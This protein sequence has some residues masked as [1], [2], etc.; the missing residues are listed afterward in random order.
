[1][2]V[3][4][5]T[6]ELAGAGRAT[7][8]AFVEPQLATLVSTPPAKGYVHEMKFD[9][10]RMLAR[11]QRGKVRLLTR[12]GNDWTAR[13]P[14]LRQAFEALPLASAL[15]DGEVV[16][17]AESGASDFQRLQNSLSAGRDGA[18]LYYAFD[19]LHLL[20]R[21]LR[22]LPLLERKRLLEQTLRAAGTR[23]GRIR[24]SD[25]NAGDGAAFLA[26][27]CRMKLEGMVSKRA[28]APYSS[29]RGRAWLKLKC[30]A[31]QE[32]VIGGYTEPGGARSH[33]GALLL[34][35]HDAEG[36][37]QYAGKVGTGFSARSLAELA[38]R[39]RKLEQTGS[40]F[41]A[42]LRGAEARGVHWLQPKLVAEVAFAERTQDR[43]VR[44]ASFLG[45]REDKLANEV[46]TESPADG[47]SV[48][49]TRGADAQKLPSG[50]RLTHPDRVLYEDQ[51]ITKRDLALYYA[52]VADWMLPHLRA[53]PLTLLRCPEGQ[54]K[55]CFFQRHP[56]LGVP[57][58][59][60]RLRVTERGK[61]V[62]AM[63]VEDLEG[64]LGLVQAGALE[65]HT[66]GSR[67]DRLEQ[68]DQLVFDLDQAE[69]VAWS[70][71]VD[72][73]RTVRSRLEALG[74]RGFV[75]TTGGK[76]LHVVAPITPGPEWPQVKE[77]CQLLVAGLMKAEPERYVVTAS[78][79]KRRG[80]VFLDYLRNVRGATAVCA[81]STRAR[82]GAPVSMPLDW[83]DL[84]PELRADRFTLRDV[85][86]HIA[87]RGADPWRDFEAAR[88]ALGAT[89]RRAVGMAR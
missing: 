85:P 8:P 51:G 88:T 44:H 74:L 71:V 49:A 17:L 62:E 78:K 47:G 81:Y 45:L 54:D 36:R 23:R 21:E 24:Y 31:R 68:P 16:V 64:L 9:G 2:S 84:T 19:L 72:A 60:K 48:A 38:A 79:A 25:H 7:L 57:A 11:L 5:T 30:Q 53:R 80:K 13:F 86:G 27:A 66:W 89:A 34:G 55:G 73:A 40:P 42:P 1:L 52:A 32:F 39:L 10:Y 28:D 82:P 26:Q 37:L 18:C 75:K 4:P 14:A 63:F 58:S 29:G 65:V 67:C 77:F 22:P 46:A 70:A 69:D 6:A 76:G 3:L 41:A 87:E 43:R 56:R 59:V 20:G 12:R 83:D 35:E 61:R 33:F 15:F 50:V